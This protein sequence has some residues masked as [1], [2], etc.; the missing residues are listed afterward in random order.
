MGLNVL[1]YQ[2]HL[3][4]RCH[5]A[6]VT[7]DI[8]I[9]PWFSSYDFLS[10]CKL[11]TLTTRQPMVGFCLLTFSRFPRQKPKSKSC[12]EKTRIKLITFALVGV[13]RLPT[14]PPGRDVKVAPRSMR[15]QSKAQSLNKSIAIQ[16]VLYVILLN[17]VQHILLYVVFHRSPTIIII[18]PILYTTQSQTY[19]S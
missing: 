3:L 17:S 13:L 9:S 10:R 1:G 4:Q 12:F 2:S 19:T 8:P 14:R 15:F 18:I 7:K 5:P 6:W 11:S 16:A